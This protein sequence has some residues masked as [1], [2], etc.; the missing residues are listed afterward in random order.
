[1]SGSILLSFALDVTPRFRDSVRD[2]SKEPGI[3]G[4]CSALGAELE[5]VEAWLG[6]AL[7]EPSL[8]ER[9]LRLLDQLEKPLQVR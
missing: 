6:H 1:M 9:L 7:N 5:Q 2:L 4:F 3:K 8:D